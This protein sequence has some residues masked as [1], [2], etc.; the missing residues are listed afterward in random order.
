MNDEY[1]I[2]KNEQQ[3]KNRERALKRIKDLSRDEDSIRGKLSFQRIIGGDILVSEILKKQIWLIS[4]IAAILFIDISIGYHNER[5]IREIDKLET[6]LV[7]AKYKA[8]TSSSQLTGK[9][10]QSKL[11]KLL[12]AKHDTIFTKEN[13]PP[14]V[15]EVN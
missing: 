7:D 3:D 5:K 1:I 11:I 4:I 6:V 2:N 15:V 9:T 12:E 8:L 13:T 14:Y 10:R